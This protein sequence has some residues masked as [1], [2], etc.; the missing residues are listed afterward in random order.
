MVIRKVL[1]IAIFLFL[2]SFVNAEE[3]DHYN[4]WY[5]TG[6]SITLAWDSAVGAIQ[7]EVELYHVE[8]AVPVAFGRTSLTQLTFICP[9]SGHYFLRA[10]SIG[11][12]DLESEYSSSDNREVSLVNGEN[13]SWWI[14]C[15]VSPPSGGSID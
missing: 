11:E 7:Y 1:Q 12:N 8:Q 5:Y 13:R 4:Y 15:R 2:A 9:R 10:K 6:D 14:Y 3:Y